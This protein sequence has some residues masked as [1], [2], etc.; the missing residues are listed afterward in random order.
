MA[1][2]PYLLYRFYLLLLSRR[3]GGPRD[4]SKLN[5]STTIHCPDS[6]TWATA[7]RSG[8][9]WVEV[10]T[11]AALCFVLSCP[12]SLSCFKQCEFAIDSTTDTFVPHASIVVRHACSMKC[13]ARSSSVD[14]GRRQC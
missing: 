5:H 8:E 2:T 14:K 7:S 11:I 10:F 13:G 3:I 4:F 12:A 1:K 6:R 9:R